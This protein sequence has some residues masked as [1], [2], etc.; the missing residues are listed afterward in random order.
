LSMFWQSY[1]HNIV[2]QCY[3][4]LVLLTSAAPLGDH[5]FG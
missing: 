3:V 1:R 5:V 2:T 4:A